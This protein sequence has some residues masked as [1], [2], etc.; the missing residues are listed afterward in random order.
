MFLKWSNLFRTER[1]GGWRARRVKRIVN[2]IKMVARGVE[3]SGDSA[4]REKNSHS[5]FILLHITL[6]P[7]AQPNA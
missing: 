1:A 2:F 4:H 5:S 7:T 3:Q 6:S